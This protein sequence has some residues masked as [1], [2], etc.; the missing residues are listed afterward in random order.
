M[1]E[2]AERARVRDCPACGE[3]LRPDARPEAVF[4][5]SVCRS[6][7]WRKEQRLRKRLAAVRDKVGLVE[8]PE[9]GARWVAGVDRRSD[10]RFC[11]RRCV[12]GAWRKRKD[13]YAD[14]AQ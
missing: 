5:S 3:R 11:S 9:C 12:V 4:C 6:R 13:P 14:R 7:Q 1:S 8:C 10:A 2:G